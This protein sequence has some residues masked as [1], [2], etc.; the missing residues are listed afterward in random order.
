VVSLPRRVRIRQ[1]WGASGSRFVPRSGSCLIVIEEKRI[2]H[3]LV[4]TIILRLEWKDYSFF[5]RQL[6][7]CDG[8]GGAHELTHA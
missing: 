4:D 5:R 8:L 7:P 6:T 1:S 2:E 3:V